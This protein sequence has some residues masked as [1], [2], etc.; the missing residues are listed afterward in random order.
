MK[1]NLLLTLIFSLLLPFYTFSQ[2]NG[3]ITLVPLADSLVQMSSCAKFPKAKAVALLNTCNLSFNVEKAE[4]NIRYFH[5]I[6]I[7]K[8]EG[9]NYADVLLPYHIMDSGKETITDLKAY[10]Y[11]YEDG[12]TVKH[13]LKKDAIFKEKLSDQENAI[14]FTLP[15][16]KEGS[17]IE[18]SY[19]LSSN[20]L[21]Y[22]PDWEFQWDIPVLKSEY[23]ASIPVYFRYAI[24]KQYFHKVSLDENLFAVD[25]NTT[26]LF[27]T[28]N[29]HIIMENIPAFQY[30]KFLPNAIEYRDK[31]EFQLASIA[32]PEKQEEEYMSTWEKLAKDL[33]ENSNFGNYYTVQTSKELIKETWT[34]LPTNK[35]KMIA[36]YNYVRKNFSYTEKDGLFVS[37][38]LNEVANAK[39]G[40]SQEINL[41]LVKMLKESGIDAYPII[42][43]LN[44]MGRVNETY[45]ILSKFNYVICGLNIDGETI[46]LDATDPFRPYNILRYECLNGNGL[47]IHSD[48]SYSW[49]ELK[50]GHT[51]AKRVSGALD[52]SAE[53]VISGTVMANISGY[54]ALNIRRKAP[55]STQKKEDEGFVRELRGTMSVKPPKPT[56][57]E[58]TFDNLNVDD[59]PLSGKMIFSSAEFTQMGDNRMY[60][61][62]IMDL[63]A[64][65]MGKIFFFQLKENP[66]KGSERIYPIELGGVGE[67]CFQI[68]ISLPTGYVVEELPKSM[69][70][71]L[72]DGAMKWDYNISQS[73]NKISISSK[74]VIS[75]SFYSNEEYKSLGDF[76]GKMVAKQEERIVIKKL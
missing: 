1:K 48:N 8:K 16:V 20:F 53:G 35:E 65:G 45:P 36:I 58:I 49:V 71:A 74:W 61:T 39:T 21:F 33:Q 46:L 56:T 32:L 67:E 12:K 30:E 59:K 55:N 2:K 5:R 57:M 76:F 24:L 38:R 52:L 9:Y 42:L 68:Q 19:T 11:N 72:Q 51:N 23:I 26:S 7:V 14:K 3:H 29:Q 63:E 54:E 18:Y 28:S 4:Y 50:S 64:K 31:L 41:L 6:K 15:N 43:S 75:R 10:T 17:V 40:S 25:A 69:K 62:P 27:E 44:T 66:F 60:I 34:N 73:G 37:H 47:A 13:E 70:L 22:L